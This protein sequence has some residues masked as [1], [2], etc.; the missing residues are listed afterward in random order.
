MHCRN[1]KGAAGATCAAS[2]AS[3]SGA[4]ISAAY[5]RS[6]S[7]QPSNPF[8]NH[9]SSE[10]R[11]VQ[12]PSPAA[13]TDI[14]AMGSMN[15]RKRSDGHGKRS[16]GQKNNAGKRVTRV[17]S[18]AWQSVDVPEMFDDAEG[19]FGLEEVEGVDVVREGDVVKFV[20]VPTSQNAGYAYLLTSPGGCRCGIRAGG[21]RW[22]RGV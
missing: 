11:P 6:C 17:D 19:F 14:G 3:K 18:L 13:C 16:K 5:Q 10:Q 8:I 7:F 12:Q 22:L 1:I 15:K 2:K 21:E 20:S 9:P 4:K